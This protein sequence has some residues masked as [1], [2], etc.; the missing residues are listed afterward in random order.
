MKNQIK[1]LAKFVS[2][3]S[4][5]FFPPLMALA[6]SGEVPVENAPTGLTGVIVNINDFLRNLLPLL[7]AI[8]V[9]Y[10]IWGV[11]R[12]MIA[13]SDEAK[14]KGKDRVIYGIIG[15]AV[16]ISVWGLVYLVAETLGVEQKF[17]QDV[18][19]LV[20]EQTEN[21]C[22]LGGKVQGLLNYATCI[23][24]QSVIPFIFAIAM[25]MFIWGAVKFFIID[26]DEEAKR[27]QGKEFMIWAVI[28][29]TVMIS[30][31]SLVKI[32]GTTFG[33]DTGFLPSVGP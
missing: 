15:L 21:T 12:Y 27:A 6:Q 25:V 8:G 18:T 20:I 30:V 14:T 33:L 2:I 11:V 13:D 28:A 17:A 5:I 3:S 1:K 24:R 10:F 23:I 19:N 22:V 31:W 7:V 4:F 32:L 9:I 16:I 26:A 29:L